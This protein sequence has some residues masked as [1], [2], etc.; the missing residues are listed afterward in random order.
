MRL[1]K[2]GKLTNANPECI[3]VVDDNKAL[4]TSSVKRFPFYWS[5]LE[6]K[7]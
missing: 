3:K 4:I 2:D 6:T 1:I 7:C 5:Y